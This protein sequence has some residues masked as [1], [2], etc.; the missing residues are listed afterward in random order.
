MVVQNEDMMVVYVV[1]EKMVMRLCNRLKA[2]AKFCRG[3]EMVE[4]D[5]FDAMPIVTGGRLNE[6]WGFAWP[7]FLSPLTSF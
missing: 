2:R 5:T 7:N 3:Y 1:A 4:S 6:S